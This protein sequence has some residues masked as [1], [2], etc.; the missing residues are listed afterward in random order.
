MKGRSI[1]Y[2]APFRETLSR[3]LWGSSGRIFEFLRGNLLSRV[4]RGTHSPNS[5]R[6]VETTCATSSR[7]RSCTNVVRNREEG[8]A[9]K[10]CVVVWI[11]QGVVLGSLGIFVEVSSVSSVPG[12]AGVASD[13]SVG[14]VLLVGGVVLGAEVDD[15]DRVDE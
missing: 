1:D 8:F 2:P 11:N 15:G 14:E 5:C 4:N 3:E 6:A 12:P 10:R 7:G 9:R 13:V